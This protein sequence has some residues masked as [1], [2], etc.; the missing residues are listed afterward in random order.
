MALYEQ[1]R[2][3]ILNRFAN[4]SFTETANGSLVS[5]YFYQ[6]DTIDSVTDSGGTARFNFASGPTLTVGQTVVNT[7]FT[8]NTAYNGTH[9]VSATDG[10][11][12][13]EVSGISFGTNETGN[14]A[15]LINSASN[16]SELKT[17]YIRIRESLIGLRSEIQITVS[18]AQRDAWT[19]TPVTG[20]GFIYNTDGGVEVWDGAAWTPV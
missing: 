6:D 12:Y 8:T 1:Y 7:G 13:F 17:A 10:T 4:H 18:E 20:E 11:T 5:V 3:D 16:Q 14:M 2:D 19:G 15:A 9:V